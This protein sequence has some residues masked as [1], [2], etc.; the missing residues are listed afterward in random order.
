MKTTTTYPE[1]ELRHFGLSNGDRL[2]YSWLR[3]LSDNTPNFRQ[4]LTIYLKQQGKEK[5]IAA[6]SEL[7]RLEFVKTVW[8][9]YIFG[10]QDD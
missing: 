7:E 9:Q 6:I 5:V 8:P 1:L 4:I 10:T 3:P 2:E